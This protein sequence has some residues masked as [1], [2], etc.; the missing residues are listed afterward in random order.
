MCASSFQ[1]YQFSVYILKSRKFRDIGIAWNSN[2][3]VI[4]KKQLNI[5]IEFIRVMNPAPRTSYFLR[6]TLYICT[7]TEE[8]F[9]YKNIY[10]TRCTF[11]HWIYRAYYSIWN[12]CSL[13]FS[14]LSIDIRHFTYNKNLKIHYQMCSIVERYAK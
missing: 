8:I 2:H 9:W 11:V 6:F 7:L 5:G 14:S 1:D 10:C 13:V 3:I 4:E 12:V